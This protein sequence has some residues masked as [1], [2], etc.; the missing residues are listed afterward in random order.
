M[1]LG[2][3]VGVAHGG[4]GRAMAEPGLD[5]AQIEAGFQQ[6]GRLGSKGG[7]LSH[8]CDTFPPSAL[9]TGQATRRCTRLA[10]DG[11]AAEAARVCMGP[12]E[13]R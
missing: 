6:V 9:R 13:S 4:G 3:E 7:A 5:Q 2:G 8:R 10:S 1:A 12:H 11:L